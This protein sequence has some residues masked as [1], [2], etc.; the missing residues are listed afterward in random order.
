MTD[1][2]MNQKLYVPLSGRQGFMMRLKNASQKLSAY[3]QQQQA[4]REQNWVQEN[5]KLMKKITRGRLKQEAY[6]ASV[7]HLFLSNFMRSK[8]KQKIYGTPKRYYQKR[9]GRR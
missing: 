3:K 1:Q 5:Q 9:R 8:L 4:K 2:P 6:K 7:G